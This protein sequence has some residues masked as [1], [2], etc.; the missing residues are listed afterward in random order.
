MRI[1][2][3]QYFQEQATTDD[4]TQ[5]IKQLKGMLDDGLITEADY[6]AKKAEILSKL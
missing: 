5:K 6:E 2:R 3:N 1:H 4:A